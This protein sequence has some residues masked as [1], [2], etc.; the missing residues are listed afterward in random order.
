MDLNV[1]KGGP[2]THSKRGT[3]KDANQT[4]GRAGISETL[5]DLV[6]FFFS[7]FFVVVPHSLG[8]VFRNR[9]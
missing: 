5:V 9:P 7:M 3:P 1:K 2:F 4:S 6:G 8:R